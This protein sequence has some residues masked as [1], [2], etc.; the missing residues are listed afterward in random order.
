MAAKVMHDPRKHDLTHKIAPFLDVHLVFPLLEFLEENTAYDAAEVQ[1][2]RLELLAP[3][4][5][6]DYAIEIHAELTG[7]EEPPAD[8]AKRSLEVNETILKLEA[9]VQ[10]E[11]A[12][13]LDA[14][15]V[16]QMMS[17][18]EFTPSHLAEK[19][20]ITAH[21]LEQYCDFGKFMY[22]CGDY[23]SARNI[24]GNYLTLL[25]D[26][27]KER[28]FRVLWGKFASEVLV[29]NWDL[30]LADLIK[31]RAAV[32]ERAA[33]PLQQLQQRSWLL[34]WSLFVFFNHAKGHDGIIDFFLNEKYLQAI[35]TN[36]PWLLRYLTS[37]VIIN[38]RRRATLK[39]LVRVITQEDALRAD[40]VTRFVE[41]LY[42]RFDFD[43]A[44]A[45]LLEC[46]RALRADYFLC[47]CADAFMED[48]RLFVF[49]T[50][51]RIHTKID[52][53]ML[54]TRLV[55]DKDDAERWIVDLIRGAL[56]DAKIDEQ[57]NCV[58]MGNKSPSVYS[59][60]IEKTRDLSVRSSALISNFD[61]KIAHPPKTAP[62]EQY[63]RD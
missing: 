30:A 4:N 15:K 20:G 63:S 28:A 42:V 22:E 26:L 51:C 3:T 56:L 48:A 41:C 49:E 55:M 43:G 21:M 35:Q 34:H 33:T 1:R 53:Q 2:A 17:A 44:Q 58:V 13:L 10:S 12:V 31:L 38:K 18:G 5:M 8:M 24:L 14:E 62:R 32:D 57:D 54:A 61:A 37:A 50:Y 52:I 46:E 6:V 59:Q 7:S 27:K 16:Q 11:C 19:H 36:C 40:P 39:D 9:Q 23:D 60:V 45:T 29:K 47:N 25:P